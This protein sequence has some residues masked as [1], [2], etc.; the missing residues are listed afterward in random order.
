MLT[1]MNE[2]LATLRRRAAHCRRLANLLFDQKVAGE[3][4]TIAADLGAEAERREREA[5]EHRDRVA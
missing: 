5:A 2:D 4:L 1:M 3:L